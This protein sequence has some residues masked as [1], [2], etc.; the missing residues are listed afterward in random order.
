MSIDV[1]D[2][3]AYRELVVWQQYRGKL[4]VDLTRALEVEVGQPGAAGVRVNLEGVTTLDSASLEALLG[5]ARTLASAGRELRLYHLRDTVRAIL[6]ATRLAARFDI[7]PP[8]APWDRGV[9]HLGERTAEEAEAS[10]RGPRA[11]F[12]L[13]AE[14]LGEP[15]EA[16]FDAALREA[17]AAEGRGRARAR[18]ATG[19]AGDAR[20][21]EAGAAPVGRDGGRRADGR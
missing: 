21:R 10:G 7:E 8:G 20:R 14:G 17:A 2:H 3:G 4:H 18:A 12:I 6:E 9:P 19:G 11:A 13:G 15:I 16:T 5:A 1:V